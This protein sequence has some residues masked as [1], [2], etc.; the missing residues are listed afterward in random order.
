MDRSAREALEQ[1]KE[2][3]YHEPYRGK[4]VYLVG[5]SVSSKSGRIK[6]WECERVW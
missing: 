6:D 2:R 4:E 1:I 5:I 3:G